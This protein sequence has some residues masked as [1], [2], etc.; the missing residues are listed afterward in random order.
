MKE[1]YNE[2]MYTKMPFGKHKGVFIKDIPT[3]YIK[4][5]VLNIQDR[6]LAFMFSIELQRRM[7]VL[8]K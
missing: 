5:A 6:A 4:W 8:K 1:Q 3:D 2:Y 7:P